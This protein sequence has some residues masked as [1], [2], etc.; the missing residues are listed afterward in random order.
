M[1]LGFRLG[2]AEVSLFP[3]HPRHPGAP[4]VGAKAL[5][6]NNPRPSCSGDTGS[7]TRPNPDTVAA[8]SF[9]ASSACYQ[10]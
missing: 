6:W 10:Q 2:P 8:A 7:G 3:R 4:V 5:P 1:G 9:V